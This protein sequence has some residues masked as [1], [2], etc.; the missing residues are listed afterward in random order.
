MFG[1]YRFTGLRRGDAA[2]LGKQH[3]GKSVCQLSA[4]RHHDRHRED[5]NA[6]DDSCSAGAGRN[7]RGGTDWRVINHRQQDGAADPQGIARN[8][9][10]EG[11]QGR[12]H[13]NK[14]AHGIRKAAATR[15][16]N[17]GRHGSDAGGDIRMEAVQMAALYTRA[18]DRE[19][20]GRR[21]HGQTV[22]NRNIYSLTSVGRCGK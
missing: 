10:Q 22:Q 2:R 12:G 16:A 5:R 20:S 13:S 21:A 19:R 11:V 6:R 18:A 4:W 15:A 1:V 17:N 14:S 9:F 3:I 7:H 8:A